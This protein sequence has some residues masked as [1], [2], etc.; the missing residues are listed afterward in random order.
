M[1]PQDDHDV[2]GVPEQ[3]EEISRTVL[4]AHEAQLRDAADGELWERRGPLRR[5][6]RSPA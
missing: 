3:F 4:A 1:H 2:P 6:V 5:L